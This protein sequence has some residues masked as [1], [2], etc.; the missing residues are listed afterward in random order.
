MN[1][2][3]QVL[4]EQLNNQRLRVC[5]L[6]PCDWSHELSD[7]IRGIVPAHRLFG[8]AGTKQLGHAV[9]SFQLAPPLQALIQQAALWRG[10]QAVYAAMKQRSTDAFV[11]TTE[12]SALPVLMLKRAGLIRKPILVLNVALLEPRNA[13]G[14][15]R[16]IWKRLLPCADAIVSYASAQ[17][18]WLQEQFSLNSD[19]LHFIPFGV[20]TNY[21]VAESRHSAEPFLLSVGTNAGKD[22]ST[23]LESLPDSARLVIVTDRWNKR[24]LMAHPKSRQVEVRN[25]VPI[26][27]L[28]RLYRD[29]A[30]QVIPLHE[31]R[32]SSGQ[33][34][35]L[36]NMAMGKT[37]IVT[38]TSAT[39][40]YVCSGVRTFKPGDSA[41]LQEHL[42]Q[43][44]TSGDYGA[45]N[46]DLARH[47]QENF[48]ADVF[49]D[50]LSKLICNLV[51]S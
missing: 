15:R 43:V 30:A 42:K 18:P 9:S 38:E 41:A 8:Y 50:S 3:A 31:T 33:T 45:I 34:V 39:R 14:W 46:N 19:I 22:F 51:K 11:C 25:D 32:F 7:Y 24:K 17:L 28:R 5:F 47:V 6:Y 4:A 29:A 16:W 26:L 23:L 13:T 12:A 21:F 36:E 40:D 20:D 27:E 1:G 44:L 2:C 10:I 37:T 49:A 48:S 35:M